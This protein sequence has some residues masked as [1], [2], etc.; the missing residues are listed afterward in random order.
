MSAGTIQWFH[1]PSLTGGVR[2]GLVKALFLSVLACG[3]FPIP[4]LAQ[5]QLP[6]RVAI[7]DTYPP[8]S[9]RSADGKLQGIS[10]DQ[11]RE[12][13]RVTGRKV[14]LLGMAWNNALSEVLTGRVDVI[15]TIFETPQR[16]KL[17]RFGPPY[18]SIVSSIFYNRK[19]SGIAQLA[20]LKG[21]RVAVKSG[22]A[23][24]DTL[25]AAGITHFAT[26]PDYASI[27][28]AA[29]L[30]KENVFSMDRPPA[31]YYLYK[32]GLSNLF[33]SSVHI[34]GGQFHR[35]VLKG[36]GHILDEV[37]AG[38]SKIP[39]SVYS[40]IE[41]R[42]IG[43]EVPAFVDFRLLFTVGGIVATAILVLTGFIF[44]MKK[45][46]AAATRELA[47]KISERD[48]NIAK[49]DA[50]I[51]AL[52]DVFLTISREGRCLEFRTSQDGIVSVPLE[53]FLGKRLS[54]IN[55]P[56]DLV[57]NAMN[58]TRTALDEKRLVV[59]EFDWKTGAGD[60]VFEGRIVPLD[61]D[62]AVLVARDITE[63]KRREKLLRN[64]L[65]EKDVL[66]REVH[67]RVK[68][69]LQIISSL[70]S[71]EKEH[72]ASPVRSE[73]RT[74]TQIRIQSM[75]KLHELLYGSTDLT[76]INPVEYIRSIVS[77][78]PKFYGSR[79]TI[80]VRAEDDN[81]SMDVAMPLGLI[82]TELLTNALKFAYPI[83]VEGSIFVGYSCMG[84]TRQLEV[85]DMGTGLPHGF[86]VEN[87]SS[88]GFTLIRSLTYQIHGKFSA[89]ET[90]SGT[91]S[92]GFRAVIAF[93]KGED[94]VPLTQ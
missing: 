31:L 19:I 17:F 72:H 64:S 68:N 41:L 42:W 43:V 53:R 24:I 56:P 58:A 87:S 81:L 70:I 75:A 15:D 5:T 84:E 20:D 9:F 51:A 85:R 11:W 2:R 89:S 8:Y 14:D 46:V 7:D 4:L 40:E 54:E 66:L 26:Y 76:L 60:R 63:T 33:K 34:P 78:V 83:D 35:A 36:N 22:D 79:L 13:E 74:E 48:H 80:E 61:S 88:L 69:N 71:L 65:R 23:D 16:E 82:L 18:V 67:H 25:R 47:K 93:P 62:K 39:Q 10:V 6:I 12:W 32:F 55:L 91:S 30:G 44:L 86:D 38:F 73:P 59:L 3:S 37:N 49:T 50:F 21:F 52:P 57:T 92:P 45:R 27:V 94:E 28:Q 29:A 90:N 77:M 1:S